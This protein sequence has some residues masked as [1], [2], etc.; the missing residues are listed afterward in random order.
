MWG[1]SIT[2]VFQAYCAGAVLFEIPT[3]VMLLRGDILL[4]N[5]GAWVD[6]KYYYT[7]NKSL[8]YVFVAILAC[9]IVSRGMACA[10]PKSRI[11]IAYLVTVHTFEAGLYLYCCK[12]KEEAPNRTVY[13]FG[14]L[15]LVNICLFCARLVQLKAQQTRAEVAGLEWRQEQL[16]IIRKNRADYAKNRGEKKNN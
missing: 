1:L 15:M 4:P 10:L 5:A 16:A 6:D 12:H 14:T 8:M 7:N 13:V 2:R 11:I 9:L 3:I